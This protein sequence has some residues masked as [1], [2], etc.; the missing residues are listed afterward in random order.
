MVL[1]SSSVW[2]KGFKFVKSLF[3]RKKRK[4]EKNVNIKGNNNRVTIK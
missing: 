1:K 3:G 4:P 2:E